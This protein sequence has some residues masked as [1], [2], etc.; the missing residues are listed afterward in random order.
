[1]NVVTLNKAGI[2][3]SE[4]SLGLPLKTHTPTPITSRSETRSLSSDPRPDLRSRDYGFTSPGVTH[5]YDQD[6][7]DLQTSIK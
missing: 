3:P 7:Q 6:R 2:F 4:S 5:S 1:M